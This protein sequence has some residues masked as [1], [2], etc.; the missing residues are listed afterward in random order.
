MK[1]IIY[2]LFLL[3]FTSK[4]LAQNFANEWIETNQIYLK[5]TTDAKGIYRITKSDLD[6]NIP[7]L[8]NV[9]PRKFQ[10]FYRGNQV[11][12]K[13]I[14]EAD[15][16]F[17]ITDEILFYGFEN[18][19]ALDKLMYYDNVRTHSHLS[20]YSIET[21][22][23]LTAGTENGNRIEEK[24]FQAN[25]L[26]IETY[27]NEE[28]LKV[29]A[30]EWIY[31]PI[32]APNDANQSK[33]QPI[34]S[35]TSTK[36][37]NKLISTT[38]NI[39]K[40]FSETIILT[41]YLAGTSKDV[42]IEMMLSNR[43]NFNNNYNY[44]FG[45][46]L[47]G[48]FGLNSINQNNLSPTTILSKQINVIN[49]NSLNLNVAST[50]TVIRD[51][52]SIYYRK[53]NYPASFTNTFNRIYKLYPN[54]NGTTVLE[55]TSQSNNLL[56]D[57]TDALHIIKYLPEL[58][59]A[60]EKYSI[61]NTDIERNIWLA[62][63]YKIPKKMAKVLFENISQTTYDYLLITDS[64]T[65]ASANRY[66]DYRET[67]MG[68]NHKV[69]VAETQ[70][71]YNQFAYGER[72]PMALKRFVAY[73]AAQKTVKNL[74]LLGQSVSFP[75]KLKA[76]ELDN[77]PD[78]DYVPT[79]GYPASD[80]HFSSGLNGFGELTP[81]IPT[82]RL[83]VNSDIEID[84]Y[85]AKVKLHD[86]RNNSDWQQNILPITGGRNTTE[87]NNFNTIMNDALSFAIN[88]D[89]NIAAYPIMN[90]NSTN[91]NYPF[92]GISDPSLYSK[93]NNGVGILSYFGHG[94]A[95][96]MQYNF[97]LVSTT[98][99][100]GG[101]IV[102]GPMN[103]QNFGKTPLLIAMACDVSDSFKGTSGNKTN[104]TIMTDWVNHPNLGA[105]N[106]IS[107]TY[108]GWEASSGPYFNDIFSIL[109]ESDLNYYGTVGELL[110]KAN[111]KFSANSNISN[112]IF[113]TVQEQTNLLGDPANRI[114]YQKCGN[115][116]SSI[117]ESDKTGNW[118]N[119]STWTCGITPESFDNIKIL[120]GH[121]VNIPTGNI[122]YGNSIIVEGNLI[123]EPTAELKLE[124]QII[125]LNKLKIK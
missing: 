4:S 19:G 125:N 18:D 89:K 62:N 93:V 88:S 123:V 100:T 106:S 85:L 13:V 64:R 95:I 119:S 90:Y 83:V 96:A 70:K 77:Q 53:I 16:S 34:E 32:T 26:P 43:A 86:L 9:D 114:F 78:D 76:K 112:L 105:L 39:P 118:L 49:G 99:N 23:F 54:V 60:N 94:T 52:F 72:T 40:P 115:I 109:F 21:A 25:I 57:V 79:F 67:N 91:G 42:K 113:N 36:Y 10:L 14:G 117:I 6:S 81:S 107:H 120:P 48:S 92:I 27:Y 2:L 47:T 65:I 122:G 15:G 29:F 97:G 38:A 69:F 63:S 71:L 17:D 110:K 61:Q 12:I 46:G 30:D 101:V 7:E 45:N 121:I 103:Y 82:G 8:S 44:N 75:T 59:G 98:T 41:N 124:N 11:D 108:L 102:G 3:Y 104:N 111:L 80:I 51:F 35:L 116:L 84:N 87:F 56:F 22:F 50:S 20:L 24:T 31:D 58:N 1:Y 55:F 33:Y 66:K 37:Y 5:I 73:M 68:G 74:F 28:L